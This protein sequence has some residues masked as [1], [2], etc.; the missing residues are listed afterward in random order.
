MLVTKLSKGKYHNECD[1]FAAPISADNVKLMG[2]MLSLHALCTVK[3][4]DM[5]VADRLY[6]GS[7]Y[8]GIFF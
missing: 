7:R 8:A 6:I 1:L 4:F 2:E 3:K 5:K